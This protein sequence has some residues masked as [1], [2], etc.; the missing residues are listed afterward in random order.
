MHAR[1]RARTPKNKYWAG[2]GVTVC[3]EW[4]DFPGFHAWAFTSGYREGLSI[5]RI[6]PD[7]GYEPG[8]CRW[9]TVSQNTVFS[10]DRRYGR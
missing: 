1:C 9:V 10:L 3:Q 4:R 7:K 2:K 8:N 6:D 5:D